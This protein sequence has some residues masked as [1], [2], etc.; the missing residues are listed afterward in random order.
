MATIHTQKFTVSSIIEHDADPEQAIL[1]LRRIRT[2]PR[3]G[4]PTG[5]PAGVERNPMIPNMMEDIFV[6]HSV[7]RDKVPAVGSEVTVTLSA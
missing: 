7:P 2:S 5:G 3:P 4:Q 6:E 1:R